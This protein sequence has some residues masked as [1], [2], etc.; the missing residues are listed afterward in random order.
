MISLTDSAKEELMSN[1]LCNHNTKAI[2]YCS[3]GCNPDSFY[4]CFECDSK[5]DHKNI[6][7]AKATLENTNA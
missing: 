5:H 7:V 6:L 1:C 4:Y 3:R 2:L